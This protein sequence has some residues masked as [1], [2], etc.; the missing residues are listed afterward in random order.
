MRESQDDM[1]QQIKFRTKI[2]FFALE[3]LSKWKKISVKKLGEIS[4]TDIFS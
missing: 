2:E 1:F 4:F 3:K